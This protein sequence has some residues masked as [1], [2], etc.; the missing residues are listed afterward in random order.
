MRNLQN[1]KKSQCNFLWNK[2]F[3]ISAINYYENELLP[4]CWS[5]NF[6]SQVKERLKSW[7]VF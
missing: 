7:T 6:K 3:L 4:I 2:Y 5:N 1:R